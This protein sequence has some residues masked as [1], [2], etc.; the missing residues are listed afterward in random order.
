MTTP[1]GGRHVLALL[2]LLYVLL[3][4]L[5]PFLLFGLG[6]ETHRSDA[7]ILQR[8]AIEAR[9]VVI[10]P[11]ANDLAPANDDTAMPI[12]EGRLDSLLKAEASVLILTW[13][14]SKRCTCAFSG[15]LYDEV[16]A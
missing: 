15:S 2:R 16:V 13:R 14:H 6:N 3:L 1:E 8:S 10:V 7:P 4:L 11:L 9:P 5:Q 12:V